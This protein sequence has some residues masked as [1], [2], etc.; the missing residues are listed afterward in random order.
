MTSR[1]T[2]SKMSVGQFRELG[3]M[4][5][6]CLP[7]DLEPD[8]A[9]S[10]IDN[11]EALRQALRNIGNLSPVSTKE[12]APISFTVTV[13]YAKTVEEM[14]AAGKYDWKNRDITSKNFPVKAGESGPVEVYLIHFDRRMSSDDAI[15]EMDRMGFRPAELPYLLAFGAKN[16]DEQR[17][18]PILALGS[19]WRYSYGRRFVPELWSGG[20]GRHLSLGWFEGGW[21]QHDRF[22]ALR[23]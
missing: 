2:A 8:F 10:W 23:K 7:D 21:H 3:G 22:L 6:R 5:I 13:D 4:V 9:Q 18:Y 14:V 16:P 20:S 17:K 1:G 12:T 15:K 19:V 11:P